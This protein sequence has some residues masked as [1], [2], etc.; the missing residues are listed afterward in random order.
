MYMESST[1]SVA[2][3][4]GQWWSGFAL[5]AKQTRRGDERTRHEEIDGKCAL[6]QTMAM[7][8]DSLGNDAKF[9]PD[10]MEDNLDWWC[11]L[12]IAF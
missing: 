12:G 6:R 1:F 7:D 4:F 11:Q 2:E 10:E 5:H 8:A 9:E 3:H